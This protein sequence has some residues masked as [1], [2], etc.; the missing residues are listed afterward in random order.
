LS[1]VWD[2]PIFI[3]IN[4]LVA[5]GLTNG[6]QEIEPIQYP[7]QVVNR[8][9][10]PYDITNIKEDDNVESTNS[11]FNVEDLFRLQRM[12][13]VVEIAL[14]KARK[15]DSEIKIKDKQDLLNAL[16]DRDTFAK[17]LQ[18]ADDTLNSIEYR[19]ITAG[20]DNNDIVDYFMKL[21]NYPDLNELRFY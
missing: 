5:K 14:A 1:P 13:F 19:D 16:T 7:C 6:E 11:H 9:Q 21:K 17:I 4:R 8:F 2:D 18:Q 12:A 20:Q 3:G 15:N 10:C